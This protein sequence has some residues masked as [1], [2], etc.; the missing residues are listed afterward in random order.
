M[1]A[2]F[3][4][5]DGVVCIRGGSTLD[6]DC[7]QNVA[8]LIR[9]TDAELV[10]SSTWRLIPPSMRL[11]HDAFDALGIKIFRATKHLPK[12]SRAAEIMR[13]VEPWK[14]QGM[15]HWAIIDDDDVRR[16][17]LEDGNVA[18]GEPD[19]TKHFVQTDRH[20]GFDGQ[21]LVRSLLLLN[22]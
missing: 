6:P 7:L 2:V 17:R 12:F 11:L 5:I 14:R 15:T 13:F 21:A 16:G 3:L 18:L 20:K 4:D 10:I 1:K 8:D 9:L 19:I 22:K